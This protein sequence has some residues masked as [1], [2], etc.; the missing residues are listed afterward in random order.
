VQANSGGGRAAGGAAGISP[1]MNG[2][3]AEVKHG[4]NLKEN[5]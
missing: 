1:A 4:E 3:Y 5:E 2:V